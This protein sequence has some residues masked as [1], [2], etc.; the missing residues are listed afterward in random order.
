MEN[1][2]SKIIDAQR[3]HVIVSGWQKHGEKVVFTN[4]CFDL[5]HRGHVEYLSKAADKGSKL[6][7][8]LNTDASVQRLKGP[9]RPIVDEESRAIVLAAFEF[10]DLVV[11]FDEDTPYELIKTVQPDVLVKGADYN[12]ED[13][14]GYDIVTQRGGSVETI[15][16]VDGFSTTNIIEKIASEVKEKGA[17]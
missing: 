12:V 14:V 9:T 17:L 15:T 5:V 10:I 2:Y 6:V 16:F 1:F 11:F 7:L 4:G 8:G 3:A 13:I